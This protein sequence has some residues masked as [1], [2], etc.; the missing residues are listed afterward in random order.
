[1]NELPFVRFAAHDDDEL[2]RVLGAV[3]RAIEDHPIAVQAAF[4]ALVREGRAFA[5]TPE[6]SEWAQRLAG[7]ELVGRLRVVWESL[8]VTA[9]TADSAGPLPTFFLDALVRGASEGGLEGRLSRLFET[10]R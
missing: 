8:S 4:A 2:A 1:V 10:E 3:R 6:G 9:F 7:S 5:A